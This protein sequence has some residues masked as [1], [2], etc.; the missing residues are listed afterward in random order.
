[1]DVLVGNSSHRCNVTLVLCTERIHTN[2][3]ARCTVDGLV[4]S[5]V[6]LIDRTLQCRQCSGV[7]DCLVLSGREPVTQC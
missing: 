1:M 3:E 4:R 6:L 5:R 7:A 2:T